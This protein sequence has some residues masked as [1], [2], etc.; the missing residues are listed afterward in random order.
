VRNRTHTTVP[1]TLSM[2]ELMPRLVDVN[3]ETTVTTSG[4]QRLRDYANTRLRGCWSGW[5][6]AGDRLV[7]VECEAPP[8]SLVATP[9]RNRVLGQI[10]L[11]WTSGG[12]RA[13]ESR[14][15]HP[16]HS[17]IVDVNLYAAHPNAWFTPIS[18]T[19]VLG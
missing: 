2:I 3:L 1:S 4:H 18:R 10:S 16:T 8:C 13:C 17:R 11:W 14:P 5:R 9:V 15:S 6:R 7:D 19:V 12:L